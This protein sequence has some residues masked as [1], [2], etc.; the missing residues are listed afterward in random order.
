MRYSEDF[1]PRLWLANFAESLGM[2]KKELLAMGDTNDPF[3]RGYI[4]GLL[5]PDVA[6]GLSA[7][8]SSVQSGGHAAF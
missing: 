5:A 7:W 1:N 8:P 2:S 6:P 4:P 3:N